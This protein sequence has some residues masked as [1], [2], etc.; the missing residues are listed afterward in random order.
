MQ[1]NECREKKNNITIKR[2]I[3][4]KYNLNSSGGKAKAKILV[5]R[6]K[7]LQEIIFKLYYIFNIFYHTNLK[8]QKSI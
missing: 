2:K 6:V 8:L 3:I 7:S 1:Q 5:W 4:S